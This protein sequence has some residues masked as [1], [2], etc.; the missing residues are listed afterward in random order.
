MGRAADIVHQHI[1]AAEFLDA[2][3]HHDG[4]RSIVGDVALMQHDF[5][6]HR[7]DALDGFRGALKIA[8]DTE[9]LG[10]FLGKPNSSGAAIAPA[11]ADAAGAG[12]DGDL[13]LQ[14]PAHDLAPVSFL[15]GANL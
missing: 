15:G 7:L 8:L 14:P 1:D 12:D 4:D 2:S 10:A 6:A 13:A 11:G 3:R 9:N 5:A